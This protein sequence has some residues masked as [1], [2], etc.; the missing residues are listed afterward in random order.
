MTSSSTAAIKLPTEEECELPPLS[1]ENGLFGTLLR[2]LNK[3]AEDIVPLSVEQRS[4]RFQQAGT[5]H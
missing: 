3:F 2:S 5:L 4:R 1:T